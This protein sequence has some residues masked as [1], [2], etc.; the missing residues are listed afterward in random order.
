MWLNG[1]LTESCGS[2]GL[3]VHKVH[4]EVIETLEDNQSQLQN[5]L[6]SKHVSYFL[7]EVREWVVKLSTADQVITIYMEVLRTWTNLESIFI[8]SEDIRR[9]L[10]E[11]AL[12]FERIDGDFKVLVA[13]MVA[14]TNVIVATGQP[15]LFERLETIQTDMAVCEK[16]LQDYM[17]IKRLAFP[18]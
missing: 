18:R 13:E 8:G 4:D 6:T 9:Q 11:P 14:S 7:N 10:P 15:R 17:E 12:R 1:L 5:L 3:T 2:V 16:A